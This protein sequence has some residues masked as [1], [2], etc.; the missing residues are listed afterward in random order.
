MKLSASSP[1]MPPT[2]LALGACGAFLF[3]ALAS[4]GEAPPRTGP[5]TE[6][7]FPPL[8]VPPGFRATLFACAP[9]IESPSAIAAGPR[10][11]SVFVAIDHLSGLRPSTE[12]RDEIRLVEDTDGDGYADKASTF[13]DGF[14]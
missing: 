6:S 7:R 9:L 4:A 8:R 2:I 10:P 14:N 12:R 1:A 13:A 3:A 5:E 11:G